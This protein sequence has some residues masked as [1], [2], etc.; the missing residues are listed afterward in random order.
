MPSLLP[1]ENCVDSPEDNNIEETR[2]NSTTHHLE[3]Q[4]GK[5]S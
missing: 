4:Q 5:E 3:H 1:E 2:T